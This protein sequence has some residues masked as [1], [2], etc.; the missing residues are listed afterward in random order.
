MQRSLS[1]VYLVLSSLLLGC[2]VG[3]LGRTAA[4]RPLGSRVATNEQLIDGLYSDLEL[5]DVQVVFRHVFHSLPER[6]VVYPSEGYYYFDFPARGVRVRGT[7]LFSANER[8]EGIASF[9]YAGQIE[10]RPF[11]RFIETPGRSHDF[12]PEDGFEFE[13]QDAFHYLAR[14]EGRE[15]L[16]EFYDPGHAAPESLRPNE[17][18]VGTSMDESGLRFDLVFDR[19]TGKLLWLLDES[20]FLPESFLRIGEHVLQGARTKFVFYF[21]RR[22]DRKVLIGVH[23]REVEYNS[24]YDGP[25]DQ[26]P[27][28]RVGLG[29]IDMRSYLAAHSGLDAECMDP[30]GELLDQPGARIPAAPYRLYLGPEEFDFVD[31]L[32]A[33]VEDTSLLLEELTREVRPEQN[34]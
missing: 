25:F 16:F 21:D 31:A 12:G 22:L 4:A 15:V 17:E 34:E 29:E 8:E 11:E 9:G 1:T 14:Y 24:W 26:L 27:D 5:E 33:R 32:V 30:F 10:D 19:N 6:V 3:R 18:Y 23:A 13:R 2:L 20:E 28:T 7:I